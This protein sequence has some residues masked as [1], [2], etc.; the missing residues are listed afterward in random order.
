MGKFSECIKAY[1]NP[2]D[3]SIDLGIIVDTSDTYTVLL[4][5]MQSVKRYVLI[6]D[7]GDSIVIPNDINGSYVYQMQILKK[8]GILLN[9]TCYTLETVLTLGSENAVTPIPNPIKTIP[10]S[11]QVLISKTPDTSVT[12]TLCNGDIIQYEYPS[13]NTLTILD[14]DGVPY[15]AG[16]K[17]NMPVFIADTVN[18]EVIYSEVTGILDN[19]ALGGFNAVS[20]VTVEAKLP[21]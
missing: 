6:V 17:I 2:C 16:K 13:G 9:D 19:T 8:D 18:Q 5:G 20:L 4:S 15:L 7:V 14:A 3:T 11:I 21:L 10:C 1:V 12:I